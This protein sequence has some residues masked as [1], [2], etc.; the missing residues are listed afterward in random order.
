MVDLWMDFWG[1]AAVSVSSEGPAPLHVVSVSVG[2]VSVRARGFMVQFFKRPHLRL[3]RSVDPRSLRAR[4]LVPRVSS[5]ASSP[6]QILGR[7]ELSRSAALAPRLR[8][9]QHSSRSNRTSLPSGGSRPWGHSSSRSQ[10]DC[11]V[12]GSRLEPSAWPGGSD[13]RAPASLRA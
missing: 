1:V 8:R 10:A 9:S 12:A 2:V 13:S 6:A 5:L 4:S 3:A 7:S 11:S